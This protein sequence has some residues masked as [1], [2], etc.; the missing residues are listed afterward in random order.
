MHRLNESGVPAGS[1]G[2]AA[3]A[4]ACEALPIFL[5]RRMISENSSAVLIGTD[6]RFSVALDADPGSDGDHPLRPG[7]SALLSAAPQRTL[8]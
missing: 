1:C 3:L 7:L 2:G 4:G 5:P 8:R 6:E